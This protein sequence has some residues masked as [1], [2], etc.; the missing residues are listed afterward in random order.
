MGYIGHYFLIFAN[1]HLQSIIVII[2]DCNVM[3]VYMSLKCNDV[4]VN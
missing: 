1:E 4:F 2:N 3:H